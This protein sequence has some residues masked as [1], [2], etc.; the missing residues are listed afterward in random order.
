MRNLNEESVLIWL[1]FARNVYYIKVIPQEIKV[2]LD[3]FWRFQGLFFT[4][5]CF[6]KK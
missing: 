1:R 3:V 4:E 6:E 5:Y 2:A